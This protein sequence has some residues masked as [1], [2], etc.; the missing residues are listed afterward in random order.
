MITR[1]CGACDSPMHAVPSTDKYVCPN[2]HYITRAEIAEWEGHEVESPISAW[3]SW[4]DYEAKLIS[5]DDLTLSDTPRKG[6]FTV[7]NDEDDDDAD[8]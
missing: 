5:Y 3:R 2:G 6:K 1:L 8:V 4:D 7:I